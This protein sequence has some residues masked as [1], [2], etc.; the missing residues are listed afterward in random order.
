M[1]WKTIRY[2]RYFMRGETRGGGT[3][4]RMLPRLEKDM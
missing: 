4:P 1:M 3:A 2:G